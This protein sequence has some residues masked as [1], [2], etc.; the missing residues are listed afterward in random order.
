MAA[1]SDSERRFPPV[2]QG[3]WAVGVFSLAAVLSYTDRQILTLLVDP[4]RADLHIS[5]TELSVLQGAAFA[6]LY[7]CV[8]LP[9][10]RIADVVPRKALLLLA[11]T[12]WSIGTAACG[13]A[14][15]FWQLFAARILVGI[16]EAAFAPA[17]MSLIADYFPPERR[18]TAVGIFFTGMAIGGGGAVSIGGGLL[19]AAQHGVFGALPLVGAL[20]PWRIVLIVAG[21]A[22]I[23]IALLFASLREPVQRA[24]SLRDLS[25]R[26]ALSETMGPFLK[27]VP[28]LLPLYAAMALCSMVDYAMLSWAPALLSR[29]FAYS[30]LEV[31]ASLGTIAISASLIGTPA[32]GYITDWCTRR[33]GASARPRLMF[34]IVVFGIFGAP[35]GVLATGT[36]TL[37]A[38]ACWISVSAVLGVVS[39]V[40]T[41][42]LL[43]IESRGL[44]TAT[45]AFSNTIFGLGLGPTLVA[46]A[47]DHLYG[48]PA[49]VG[50]A[51]TTVVTP[52][53]LLACIFYF[54]AWQRWDRMI[55]PM[56]W[57]PA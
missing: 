15:S 30:P 5:D 43:P 55:A 14:G 12:V 8:G 53:I 44:A 51:I 10:G 9:L 32:G 46:L 42:D 2:V 39:I 20:A 38:A 11:V 28:L 27:R 48:S 47:T 37:I 52:L 25:T 17:A 45:I 7:A 3:W 33:W 22:G 29:T 36:Q 1:L 19:E 31:G 6:V 23:A 4:L 34:A 50:L 54:F 26:L 24:F 16:G 13:F 57:N 56:A 41:L 21:G 49:A 40:A 18:A 35:M